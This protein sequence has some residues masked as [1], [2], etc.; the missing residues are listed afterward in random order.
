MPLI[1]VSRLGQVVLAS[2]EMIDANAQNRSDLFQALKG[3]SNNFGI[4]TR[5]DLNAFEQGPLWGGNVIYPDETLR[6][7]IPAVVR[8]TDALAQYPYAHLLLFETYS[9]ATNQT[10][11][12]NVYIY[13]KPESFPPPFKEL[14]AIEPAIESTLRIVNLTEVTNVPYSGVSGRGFEGSVTLANRPSVIA[15]S[16]E[17]SAAMLEPLKGR[18][19]LTWS[20]GLQPIPRLYSDLSV[21]RGGNVLGL[22]RNPGNYI[23]ECKL[24]TCFF[25]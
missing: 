13:T 15:R 14:I 4:V 16:F 21:E 12:L 7:H 8:F 10:T 1:F 9:S 2:G 25:R 18:R 19:N 23:C 24:P 5:L 11:I 6:Q 22:D 17:I 20:T 3:G